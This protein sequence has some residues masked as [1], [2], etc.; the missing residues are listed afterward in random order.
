MF[1]V[2]F[3]HGSLSRGGRRRNSPPGNAR[4]ESFTPGTRAVTAPNER[5]RPQQDLIRPPKSGFFLDGTGSPSPS[6]YP[7]ALA[8]RK[9]NSQ[10]LLL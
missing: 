4:A 7:A 8:L 6:R 3:Q 2:R 9:L 5:A 10:T 1:A